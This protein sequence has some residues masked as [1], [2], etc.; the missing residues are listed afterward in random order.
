MSTLGLFVRDTEVL[1]YAQEITLGHLDPIVAAAIGRT[2]G[3]V[4]QHA[5]CARALTRRLTIRAH[6]PSLCVFGTLGP[7]VGSPIANALSRLWNNPI[8]S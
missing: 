7:I 8:G 2:L 1:C 5:Q 6:S 3:T 4:I